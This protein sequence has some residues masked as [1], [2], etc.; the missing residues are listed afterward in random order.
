MLR[1][2][3]IGDRIEGPFP[4]STKTVEF[5]FAIESSSYYQEWDRV[6]LFT[7]Y[8]YQQSNPAWS[9]DIYKV[10]GQYTGKVSLQMKSGSTGVSLISDPLPIFNGDIFSVM[11]RRNEV[12]SDFEYNINQNAAPIQY[13]LI[14]QRNENGRQIFYSITSSN[15]SA[16]DNGIF[17]QYGRFSLFSMML[18]QL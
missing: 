16:Q 9:V 8:P 2:S 5:K 13:D 17:S 10:P 3:G 11:L 15:F 4:S 12:S 1:F 7:L 14:V 18:L 6:S